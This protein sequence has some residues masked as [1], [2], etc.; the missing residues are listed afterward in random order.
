MIVSNVNKT[1]ILKFVDGADPAKSGFL[2]VAE[3]MHD[4]IKQMTNGG[5]FIVKHCSVN[6]SIL[7][8]T[9]WGEIDN[10]GQWI[11]GPKPPLVGSPPSGTHKEGS[12]DVLNSVSFAPRATITL[13]A[14]GPGIIPTAGVPANQATWVD[15][16]NPVTAPWT[17]P[18]NTAL[19]EAVMDPNPADNGTTGL[20]TV[21]GTV[22]GLIRVGQKVTGP[23]I[24][25]GK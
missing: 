17:L 25:T 5:G 4:V 10:T 23:G 3:L 24:T 22:T 6:D 13:E 20:M 9:K 7:N 12:I 14:G 2:N 21:T 19:Y 11:P 1:K 18:V 15:Y 16:L 8:T